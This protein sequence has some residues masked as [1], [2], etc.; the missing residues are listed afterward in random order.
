MSGEGHTFTW[1]RKME[2]RVLKS[3]FAYTGPA[4]SAALIEA[5]PGVAKTGM[6]AGAYRLAKA[7]EEY[8]KAHHKWQNRTTAAEQSLYGYAVPS[9]DGA[10]AGLSYRKEQAH[11]VF[12]L[13]NRWNGRYAIIGPTQQLFAPKAHELFAG[14][15]NAAMQGR[16]SKFRSSQTGRFV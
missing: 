13:E 5:I 12:W 7:M 11:Y 3:G 9:Q 8:A 16:G 2:T 4:G 10:I 6:V 15:I 1:S 14:E